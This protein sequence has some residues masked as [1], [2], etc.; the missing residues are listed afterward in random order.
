MT[1]L[2]ASA[3]LALLN[4]EPGADVVL[5]ALGGSIMSTVNFAEVLSKAVERGA[6][7]EAAMSD[8]RRLGVAIEPFDEGQAIVAAGL[9]RLT[10]S[11]GLSIGDRACLA[12]AA[13]KGAD[14]LTADRVWASLPHGLKV[15]LIR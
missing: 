6:R 4:G 2:D 3:L 15:N 7:V 9:R 11:A 5:A 12:L 8:I 13:V 1:V 10:A 14:V